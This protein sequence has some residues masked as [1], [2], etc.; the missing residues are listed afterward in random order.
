MKTG[1]AED[2]EEHVGNM[3]ITTGEGAG[4]GPFTWPSSGGPGVVLMAKCT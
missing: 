2:T 1:Q 4:I 3:W